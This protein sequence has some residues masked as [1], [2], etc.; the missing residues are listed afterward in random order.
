MN[1]KGKPMSKWRPEG[2]INPYLQQD[3]RGDYVNSRVYEAGA[4]AM[5]EALRNNQWCPYDL[6]VLNANRKGEGDGY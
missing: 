5:L 1:M 4:D 2:W 6:S 3:E